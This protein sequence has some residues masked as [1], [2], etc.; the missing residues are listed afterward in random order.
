MALLLH[1]RDQLE[2]EI[3]RGPFATE[4]D[5]YTSTTSTL[6]LHADCLPLEHHAFFAP[7]PMQ[8]VYDNYNYHRA[9]I[10]RWIDLVTVGWRSTAGTAG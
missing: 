1:G 10:D 7:V 6:G 8:D 4:C 3:A 9:A 2:E 5:Y